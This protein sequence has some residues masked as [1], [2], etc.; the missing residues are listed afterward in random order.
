MFVETPFYE[1]G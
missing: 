1:E